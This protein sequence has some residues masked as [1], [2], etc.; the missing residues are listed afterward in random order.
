MRKHGV[1]VRRKRGSGQIGEM[2]R[3]RVVVLGGD[4]NTKC[5]PKS[6][7]FVKNGGENYE[8]VGEQTRKEERGGQGE[9]VGEG[10]G[11]G[12]RCLRLKITTLTF[13]VYR[14]RRSILVVDSSLSLRPFMR[15]RETSKKCHFG[16]GHISVI[17]VI[18]F[19]VYDN[20]VHWTKRHGGPEHTD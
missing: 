12:E 4:S 6:N 1:E 13:N 20:W 15:F 16:T 19:E 3:G 8:W 9:W 5:E 2:G 14:L 18:L 17:I 11:T 7:K 10:E